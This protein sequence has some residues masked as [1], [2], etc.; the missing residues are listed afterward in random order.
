MSHVRLPISA[1][2]AAVIREAVEADDSL[3]I[4]GMVEATGI[5]RATLY[6]K[7]N[8]HPSFTLDELVAVTDYIGTTPGALIAQAEVQVGAA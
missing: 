8:G 3:S 2:A 5:A 6:R 1:A 7:L 4:D